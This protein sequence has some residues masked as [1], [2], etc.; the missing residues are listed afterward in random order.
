MDEKL[1]HGCKNQ[2]RKEKNFPKNEIYFSFK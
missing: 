2:E 1:Q